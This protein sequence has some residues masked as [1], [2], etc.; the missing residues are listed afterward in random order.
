MAVEQ[1]DLIVGPLIPAAGVSVISV[2]FFVERE[3]WLEVY[4]STQAAALILG[5]DYTVQGEGTTDA[6]VTLA[7]PANGSDSYAV[8]YRVP[9]ERT[10]DFPPTGPFLVGTLNRDLD[11]IVSMVAGLKT[12]IDR[13]LR[14]ADT[15]APLP[16]FYI[17]PGAA[18]GGRA[19]VWSDDSSQ[20]E[21]GPTVASI[22]SAE[23]A[24]AAS[25]SAAA[26]SA[27]AA[28]TSKNAAAG[29]ASAAAASASAAAA[30]ASAAET[31]KDDAETAAT[32]AQ[33]APEYLGNLFAG[34]Q[35]IGGL[36]GNIGL[37]QWSV[38]ARGS[39][40]L[41]ASEN[42]PQPFY[43]FCDAEEIAFAPLSLAV[44]VKSGDRLLVS[45]LYA[46]STP[47]G[48]GNRD[49]SAGVQIGFGVGA[50]PAL[51]DQVFLVREAPCDATAWQYYASEV[52]VPAGMDTIFRLRLRLNPGPT[53]GAV[54]LANVE[55]RRM[56]GAERTPAG[57]ITT[58]KLSTAAKPLG[59]D[60]TNVDVT[61]SRA[62][63]TSYQNTTGR[64]IAVSISTANN[65]TT[66]T[67]FTFEVSDDGTTWQPV[68]ISGTGN[69]ANHA[70]TGMFI[71]KSG[72]YY[73]VTKGA[74]NTAALAL[75][76]ELR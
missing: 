63:N 44:P 10:A 15:S 46:G 29:S 30:S 47:G 62:F 34:S 69:Y 56:D 4:R 6:T 12:D 45:F 68:N 49:S 32:T 28:N 39:Q 57:A 35:L 50:N 38:Q 74:A 65:S 54:H 70:F 73:R 17:A 23:T 51:E 53:F 9:I 3:E 16:P 41:V 55:V 7:T 19:L 24:A 26:A 8:R 61:A 25:A 20:L 27:S 5:T 11:R 72:Q 64:P 60:Q 75:W 76:T 67:V 42:S 2:D 36:P 71:V 21:P 43:W 18:T 48:T 58:S 22:F 33:N 59:V 13:T 1:N 14:L 37:D 66:A 40:N 31:A 52:V